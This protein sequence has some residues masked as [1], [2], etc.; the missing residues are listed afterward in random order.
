MNRFIYHGVALLY[1]AFAIVLAWSLVTVAHA[2]GPIGTNGGPQINFRGCIAYEHANFG[3]G[4]FTIR[5]NYNMRYF[6]DRWNDIISSIACNSYCTMRVW[7]HRDLGVAS[8]LF[9]PEL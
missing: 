6:V 5:G 4:K 9:T 3:G 1:G 2:E 7:E 8:R